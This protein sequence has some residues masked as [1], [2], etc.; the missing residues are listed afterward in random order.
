MPIKYSRVVVNRQQGFGKKLARWEQPRTCVGWSRG[1]A[2]PLSEVFR[3][4]IKST[5][6]AEWNKPKK[7]WHIPATPLALHD[8]ADHMLRALPDEQ[9]SFGD[10]E[11]EALWHQPYEVTSIDINDLTNCV[12]PPWKNQL[13]ASNGVGQLGGILL[14]YDMGSGKSKLILDAM[15]CFDMRRVLVFCPA[16]VVK[17]WSYQAQQHL[18]QKTFPHRIVELRKGSL[19]DRRK[20][21]VRALADADR[22]GVSIA[23]VLNFEAVASPYGHGLRDEIAG[24]EWDLVVVDESHRVSNH[25]TNVSKFL[26]RR[27]MHMAR[28]RVCM[29]G[30]PMGSGPIDIFGQMLFVEPG[31]FGESITRFRSRFCIMGGFEDKQILRYTNMDE[32]K[33]RLGRVALK[34]RIED[35]VEL[36]DE[37]DEER[38]IEMKPATLKIYHELRKEFIADVESGVVL[39]D[40][41]LT[42]L[43]RL[44]QITSGFTV[45]KDEDGRNERMV[46][47]DTAKRDATLEILRDLPPHEPFV[48]FCRFKH[49][50]W[51]VGRAAAATKTVDMAARP[52]FLLGD[53]HDQIDEWNASCARGEGPVFAVQIQAGGVGIDLTAARYAIYYSLSY[54]PRDYNQSRARIHRPGQERSVIYYHLVV[55]GT[56]DRL[57][58]K[59]LDRKE[60][61]VTFARDAIL[62]A[63]DLVA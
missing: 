38:L 45:I 33:R 48:A 13:V 60:K 25:T 28:H 14:D 18:R 59:S 52:F 62:R 10:K 31:V 24:R 23:L 16:S 27:V 63:E 1:F 2:D 43:I 42:R 20:Q 26:A 34:C 21:M 37:V 58:Y 30:T 50:L 56:V 40:N 19:A 8:C 9:R 35:V 5:G 4:A 41:T 29:S 54:D 11:T 3:D 57:I 47:L 6:L 22:D 32:F 39:G 17:V 12:F 55:P 7:L 36:P 44:Q 51:E 15:R 53:Q 46:E 49:D 61:L